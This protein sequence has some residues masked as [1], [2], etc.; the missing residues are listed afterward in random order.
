MEWVDDD[1]TC[2]CCG[3][4]YHLWRDCPVAHKRIEAYREQQ[5]RIIFGFK[6]HEGSLLASSYHQPLPSSSYDYYQLNDSYQTSSYNKRKPQYQYC[7]Q[8]NHNQRSYQQG[9]RDNQGSS[10]GNWRGQ[11]NQQGGSS[12]SDGSLKDILTEFRK[13]IRKDNKIREKE[14]KALVQQ[15]A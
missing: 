2:P 1:D 8:G 14:H 7:Q 6:N 11:S 13:E 10:Q 5:D 4:P 3:S 9:S 15:V 12:G